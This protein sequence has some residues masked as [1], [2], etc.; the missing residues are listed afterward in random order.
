[1]KILPSELVADMSGSIGRMTV[2]HSR[3]GLI[4]RRTP[5]AAGRVTNS[6]LAHRARL[7]AAVDAWSALPQANRAAWDRAVSDVHGWAFRRPLSP[8]TGYAYFIAQWS[9]D[10][11]V[12]GTPSVTPPISGNM[13]TLTNLE[14]TISFGPKTFLISWL[15]AQLSDTEQLVATI[16]ITSSPTSSV[17]KQR[18]FVS[19]SLGSNLWSPQDIGPDL[20]DTWDLFQPGTSVCLQSQIY[21]VTLRR[22]GHPNF[23]R[24]VVAE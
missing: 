19:A 20:T 12:L 18:P 1:M 7:A 17:G 13:R 14:L 5:S 11:V 21:D 16:A 22:L 23:T 8:R 24:S 3:A 10:S 15:P 2:Q 6:R 9:I 4:L